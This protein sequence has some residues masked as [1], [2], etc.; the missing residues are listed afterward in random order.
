M[1]LVLVFMAIATLVVPPALSYM[2]T[3][4]KTGMMHEGRTWQL[5]AAE[6]GIN[7]GIW[8][9]RY[10]D[11][12]TLF[13]SAY[14]EYDYF[15]SWNYNMAEPVNGYEVNVE[16]ENVWLPS[17]ITAPTEL[18]ARTIIEKGQLIITGS[19]P[20]ETSTYRIR[21]SFYPDVQ[22]DPRI[23]TLGIWLP[24]GFSYVAGSSNLEEDPSDPFYPA[25]VDV[26]SH[27]GGQAVIWSFWSVPIIDFGPEV[28]SEGE[29]ITSTITFEYTSVEEDYRPS[30]VS[31]V[32]TSEE[33][34]V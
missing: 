24:P 13:G 6:S 33:R 23:E 3:G 30:A 5:Y 16:I 26:S 25:S 11:F 8:Y 12:S 27:A 9:A 21:L 10:D 14:K 17:N 18:E 15:S 34:I 7:D 32:T 20:P 4:L 1:A 2:S 29:T 19:A 22:N 31:W 28:E